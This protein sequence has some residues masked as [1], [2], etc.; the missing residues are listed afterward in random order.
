MG[1]EQNTTSTGSLPFISVVS[2]CYNQGDYLVDN[3]ESVLKQDYPAFEHIVVDDGSTDNT[4]EVCER[5]PHVRYI[6]QDNAGQSAA[7][8]RGFEEAKGDI[9]AWVNSDDFYVEGAFHRVGQEVDPARG[10]YIVAGAAQV[11]DADGKPLWMLW[12]GNVSFTRLLMHPRLYPFNGWMVMPCQPSVFFHR[13]LYEDLGPLQTD[14][15][16]GMDYEYWLRAMVKGYRFHYV[17]QNLSYYRYHDTSHTHALGYDT[18]LPEWEA[19]S[20]HYYNRLPTPR[21]WLAALWWKYARVESIFVNRH[22]TAIQHMAERF[23]SVPGP[24]PLPRKLA[25]VARATLTAPWIPVTL[26]WRKLAPTA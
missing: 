24:H 8:N 6:Y 21:R 14:L 2:C 16:Y 13:K 18:F 20:N 26:L 1:E 15:K 7:L 5:Y 10:R 17:R 25:V 4:R 11:T 22:K 12:N 9:I 19:V 23:L 3:I